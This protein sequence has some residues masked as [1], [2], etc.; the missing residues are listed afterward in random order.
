MATLA[1]ALI[2]LAVIAAL[3]FRR[4]ETLRK[5]VT[6]YQTL[7][8]DEKWVNDAVRRA[9]TANGKYIIMTDLLGIWATAESRTKAR[10][11]P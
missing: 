8:H 2:V 4:N 3:L 5:R 10:Q 6:E 1:T 9:A 11:I 7:Y